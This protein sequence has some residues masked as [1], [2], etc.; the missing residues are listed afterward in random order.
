[1]FAAPFLSFSISL[2]ECT[3]ERE[4]CSIQPDT[5]DEMRSGDFR[6]PNTGH[7]LMAVRRLDALVGKH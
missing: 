3:L 7:H 1:M 4:G 2:L 6:L 5:I